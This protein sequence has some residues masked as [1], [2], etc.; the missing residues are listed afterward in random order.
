MA[1]LTLGMGGGGGGGQPAAPSCPEDPGP[2]AV[3]GRSPVGVHHL[4]QL[5]VEDKLGVPG[6]RALAQQAHPDIGATRSPTSP[7]HSRGEDPGYVSTGGCHC[8]S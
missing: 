3:T 4:L 8:L 2:W 5:V 7:E 6:K 1:G